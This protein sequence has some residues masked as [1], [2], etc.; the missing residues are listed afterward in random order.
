MANMR[1]IDYRGVS[2]AGINSRLK[3]ALVLAATI[4]VGM[5]LSVFING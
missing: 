1:N 5:V 3:Q 4:L 2:N